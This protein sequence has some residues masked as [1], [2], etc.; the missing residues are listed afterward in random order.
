MGVERGPWAAVRPTLVPTVGVVVLLAV[1][2]AGCTMCPDP[3]DYSG[4]V[5]NGSVT[6]NDFG[7]RSNGILPLRASPGPWPPVVE[8]A[9]TEA[10]PVEHGSGESGSIAADRPAIDGPAVESVEGGADGGET[11]AVES[12]LRIAEAPALPNPNVVEE[13]EPPADLGQVEL[14]E[15]EV[16]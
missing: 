14:E 3:F 13:T 9:P 12:V 16:R 1:G 10:D 6:Q 8:G 5:P 15:S 7:G 2:T 11:V 4:P